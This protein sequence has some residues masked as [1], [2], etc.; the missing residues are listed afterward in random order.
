MSGKWGTLPPLPEVDSGLAAEER[1]K[2]TKPRPMEIEGPVLHQPSSRH[3]PPSNE[4]LPAGQCRTDPVTL[5]TIQLI[6]H[7]KEMHHLLY[8]VQQRIQDALRN[9]FAVDISEFPT[10]PPIPEYTGPGLKHI[11]KTSIPYLPREDNDFVRGI[12]QSPPALDRVSTQK[13]LKRSVAT[14]CAHAGYDASTDNVLDTL[15]DVTQEFYHQLTQSLRNV[16][17]NEA[18]NGSLPF[19]DPME[20]VFQELG[21][22]SV[23]SIHDFYQQRILG[24]HATMTETCQQLHRD[25]TKLIHQPHDLSRSTDDIKV[26]KIKDEPLTSI[27][28]PVMEDGEEFIDTEQL[29]QLEGFGGLDMTAAEVAD[30]LDNIKSE[31]IEARSDVFDEPQSEAEPQ[32][33]GTGS[34]VGDRTPDPNFMTSPTLLSPPS[35]MYMQNRAKRKRKR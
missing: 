16:V 1:Q 28:F 34:E 32:T 12:G 18:L 13:L 22:G 7:A 33:P 8:T 29:L 21:L 14:I 19:K 24:Y 35:A 6:Q 15:T 5:H 4:K 10:A 30:A 23:T 31:D 9:D 26:L 2:L 25:Y 20:Q 17:D 3:R 27:N 11:V